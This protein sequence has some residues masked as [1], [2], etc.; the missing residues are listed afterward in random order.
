MIGRSEVERREEYFKLLEGGSNVCIH[1]LSQLAK[2]C[3]HNYPS[4]RPSAERVLLSLIGDGTDAPCRELEKQIAI[5]QMKRLE[6]GDEVQRL[7]Q[8][9]DLTQV[10]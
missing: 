7:Q 10:Y 4:R 2:A 6:V 8:Q 9:L 5:Q 1:S 3:L